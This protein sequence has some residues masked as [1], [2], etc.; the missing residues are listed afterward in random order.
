MKT[1]L[2]A[3]SALAFAVVGGP[4]S[5]ADWSTVTGGLDFS[6]EIAGVMAI[7]GVLAGFYVVRKGA[8]LLL[9]MIK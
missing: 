3:L 4:V 7:V 2:T 5:A 6:G 9:S 1:K 8:R